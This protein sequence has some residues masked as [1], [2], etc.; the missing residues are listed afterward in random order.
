MFIT[1]VENGGRIESQHRVEQCHA[2]RFEQLY[3]HAYIA[4][5]GVLELLD[6]QLWKIL[7]FLDCLQPTDFATLPIHEFNNL[8]IFLSGE[9]VNFSIAIVICWI[10][11]L[12]LDVAFVTIIGSNDFSDEVYSSHLHGEVA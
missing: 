5:I 4:S 7:D 10:R 12:E 6:L 11:S 8:C 1:Y 2:T 3:D 9:F